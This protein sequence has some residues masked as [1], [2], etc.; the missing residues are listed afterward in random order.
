MRLGEDVCVAIADAEL[1]WEPGTKVGYHAYT[2]GYIVGEI[3]SRVTGKPIGQVLRDDVT[4]PLGITDELY[5]GMPESEHSRLARLEDAPSEWDLSAMPDDLPMFRAGPISLFPTAELGNRTDL[6]LAD[7]PAG[8]KTTARAIARMYAALL[9][10]VDGVRLVSPER[11]RELSTSTVTGVDEVFGMASSWGL[12]FSVGRPGAEPDEAPTVFGMA[13]AGGSGAYADTASGI[14][15]A[16]T[17]NR[18]T[19]DFEVVNQI[20]E[21]IDKSSA[22]AS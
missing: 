21:I 19:D 2:F 3:A 18:M 4:T 9:G 7:I 22:A 5:F 8:G 10:E 20:S 17:K 15:F 13:G 11:L 1:W 16:V 12:G 14:S 6:L